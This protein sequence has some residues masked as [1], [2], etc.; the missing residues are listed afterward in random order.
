MYFAP[1]S[2]DL[3]VRRTVGPERASAKTPIQVELSITNLGAHLEEILLE[4]A[5]PPDLELLEGETSVFTELPPGATVALSY[6]VRGKRGIYLFSNLRATAYE[7]LGLLQR[8]RTFEAPGRVFVVPETPQLKRV[9]IRPRQTRVYSGSIPARQGGSGIDFFGV[10]SYQ[11][12]DPQQHIN[13]RVSARH[14]G[15]LFSNEYEQERVADVWLLLDARKRSDVRTASG[16]LFEHAVTATA[17]LAQALL[18]DGN[19]VGLLVYGGFLDYTYPGYGKVQRERIWRALAAARPG[20][21]L[22]FDKLE[23]LP[24]RV[25]P[26]NS[27]LMLISPLNPDDIP[28][29]VHLRSRGYS[30]L[31]I[32]PNPVKFET[33]ELEVDEA[34]QL[35][36]R[37][38]RLERK[39]LLSRLGQAGVHVQNWDVSVPFDRAMHRSLTRF[40]PWYHLLGMRR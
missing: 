2:P 29:L 10:R 9:A 4:D 36:L 38:A 23:H 5:V 6:T 35:G 18:N 22:V 24:T 25:F 34:G 15:A 27:Q 11:T 21:S 33:E 17:G 40:L 30:V 16:S 20:D 3:R 28:I 1:P 13:W 19:R 31:A 12:G 39:L 26:L 14:P 37:L 7:R 8:Q 32:S